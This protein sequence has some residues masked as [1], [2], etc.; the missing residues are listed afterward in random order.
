MASG[1]VKA[2]STE[3]ARALLA[4]RGAARTARGVLIEASRLCE[5]TSEGGVRSI[6]AALHRLEGKI[7]VQLGEVRL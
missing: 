1:G 7:E 3:E 2:M 4:W 5:D 6:V